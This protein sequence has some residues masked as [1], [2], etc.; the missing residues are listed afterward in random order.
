MPN[1]LPWTTIQRLLVAS[2][3]VDLQTLN[4]PMTKRSVVSLDHAPNGSESREHPSTTWISAP[5]LLWVT[6]LT[7]GI[8][9][10]QTWAPV[11]SP[12]RI[13]P[14]M[15]RQ[16]LAESATSTPSEASFGIWMELSL[17]WV[18]I[19]TPRGT[20]SIISGQK[21]AILPRKTNI[22]VSSVTIEFKSDRSTSMVTRPR[23]STTRMSSLHS[24]LPNKKK[25]SKK[26]S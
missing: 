7:A 2:S 15:N 5:Q 13:Y 17:N 25:S 6:A 14:L 10:R 26:T 24:S 16:F 1:T 3:L 9:H 22:M 4:L 18:Q 19:L 21:P 8:R 23:T 12:L 20:T 11:R